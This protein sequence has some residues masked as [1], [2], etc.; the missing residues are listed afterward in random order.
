V[1]H[2]AAQAGVRV[3]VENPGKTHEVNVT[4]T[5]NVLKAAVDCGIRAQS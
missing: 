3:S 1:F 5:L 4:G 2:N